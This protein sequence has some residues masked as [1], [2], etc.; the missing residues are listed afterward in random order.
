MNDL[1]RRLRAWNPV[2]AEEMADAADSAAAATL[3]Q[4]VL[5]QPITGHA[6]RRS[7][8][9]RLRAVAGVTAVAAAAALVAVVLQRPSAPRVTANHHHPA[10]DMHLVSFTVRHGDIIARITD[11]DA[12]AG[13]LTAVFRAYGLNITV[14]AVPV[15]PSLVGT[16]VFSQVSVR[17]L[18][19]PAC[20]LTGCPV[21]L[22]IPANFTGSGGVVVGRA[23]QRG[24]RYESMSDSFAPGEALH[25]SGLAGQPVS[26]ALPVLRTL[27]LR[28]SWTELAPNGKGHLERTPA[29]YIVDGSPISATQVSLDIQ[30]TPPHDSQFRIEVSRENRGCR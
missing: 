28:A 5:D 3:L 30:P 8:R 20:S 9:H 4:R 17:S 23:A 29:G 18:W 27:G 12:A 22:V 25:C 1:D 16:I 2:R 10:P 21:G 13:Q 6:R 19:K 24:E 14:Q 26:A 7:T 15:S 11:P